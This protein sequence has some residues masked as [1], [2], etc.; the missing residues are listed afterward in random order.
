MISPR[1]GKE[2]ARGTHLGLSKEDSHQKGSRMLYRKDSQ[3]GGGGAV[4]RSPYL[5]YMRPL[6]PTLVPCKLDLLV[7][8]WKRSIWE[9]EARGSEIQG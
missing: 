2:R 3:H 9:V 6:A 4:H 7:T 5:A 8:V 1:C